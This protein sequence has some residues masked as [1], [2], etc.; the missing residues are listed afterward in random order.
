MTTCPH[1]TTRFI[2]VDGKPR[3]AFCASCGVQ[4]GGDDVTLSIC[5]CG[6]MAGYP[7]APDCPY[8]MYLSTD[9]EIERWNTARTAM[10]ATATPALSDW[11][12]P[13]VA[14]PSLE[15][16]VEWNDDDGG[17]EAT[18]GCWVEPDGT[19]RHGHPSWL[20]VLGMI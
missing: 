8:P 15:E 13:T 12:T 4:L 19:C 7:H 14:Q 11:P 6:A 2:L 5:L 1:P 3:A 16:L 9:R 10:S 20:L 18:D 17:C